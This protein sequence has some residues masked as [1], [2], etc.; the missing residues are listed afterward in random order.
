MRGQ[1]GLIRDV[2]VIGCDGAFGLMCLS[3]NE[4]LIGQPDPV[5]TRASARCW[6][7]FR[8]QTLNGMLNSLERT[9]GKP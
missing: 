9:T 7:P 1:R 2:R 3:L 5:E 8:T 4:D 6:L